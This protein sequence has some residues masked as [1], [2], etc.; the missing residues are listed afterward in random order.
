MNGITVVLIILR[1]IDSTLSRDT[2]RST[3]GVVKSKAVNLVTKL[4]K[5]G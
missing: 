3:G 1:S 4:G 2:M 5:R